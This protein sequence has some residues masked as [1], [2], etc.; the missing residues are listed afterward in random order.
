MGIVV[1]E[2]GNIQNFIFY[3]SGFTS[4]DVF[5]LNDKINQSSPTDTSANRVG[6][7]K[8]I[9]SF[10]KSSV[11]GTGFSMKPY[12]L[13]KIRLDKAL[14]EIPKTNVPAGKVKVWYIY[15]MGL[16]VK[17]EKVTVAF[18][19]SSTAVY[20]N[21]K[22][23]TKYIDILITSHYHADHFDLAVVREALKNGVTVIGPDDKVSLSGGQYIR[24][25]NGVDIISLIKNKNGI[26][27]ENFFGLTPQRQ[28]SVKGVQITS[29]P[30]N[31]MYNSADDPNP[32]NAKIPAAWYYVTVAGKNFLFAGD[33]NNFDVNPNFP[34]KKVDVFVEHY[35]DPKTTDDFLK[36]VPNVGII[37]PLHVYE[38]LHGSGI[39]DYMSYKNM[40]EEYSNGFL[41]GNAG[42]RFMPLIWG[43]SFEL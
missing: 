2:S 12:N 42:M 7:L 29:Y 37:L 11:Q 19:L 4:K 9:D 40:L 5:S 30:A 16:I 15:D 33:S 18:D 1:L 27:S 36:L 32:E 35:V 34:A 24:D 23:F 41:R 38:L 26:A 25:P 17:S 21:M 31:H 39:T 14:A 10:M 22:D 28:T 6:L 3:K 43:E 13:V 8:N 20:R